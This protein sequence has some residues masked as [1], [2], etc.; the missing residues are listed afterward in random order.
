MENRKIYEAVKN[1]AIKFIFKYGSEKITNPGFDLYDF[2]VE[3]EHRDEVLLNSY[4]MGAETEVLG[5]ID[6]LK[7]R[8]DDT[9]T[10]YN[11]I[12][13][14]FLNE[15]WEELDRMIRLEVLVSSFEIYEELE[16]RQRAI[17][18]LKKMR[19]SYFEIID[20]WN[21]HPDMME[22]ACASFKGAEK[23]FFTKSFDE[24]EI[25]DWAFEMMEALKA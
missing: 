15:N 20:I 12:G 1:D 18:S 11:Y 5:N 10:D 23:P 21:E 8:V 13:E 9:C 7:S 14:L 6:I 17:K 24:L 2:I 22:N 19:D 4:Y 25:D 3:H 16:A